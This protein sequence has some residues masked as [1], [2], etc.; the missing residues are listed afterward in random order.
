MSMVYSYIQY[1]LKGCTWDESPIARPGLH[2]HCF[3]GPFHSVAVVQVAPSLF[4]AALL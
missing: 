2:V 1:H 3:S 4:F